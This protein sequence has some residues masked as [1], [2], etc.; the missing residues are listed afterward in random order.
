MFILETKSP[1]KIAELTY[2][3]GLLLGSGG[4]IVVAL[5]VAAPP[6]P[7]VVA[8]RLVHAVGEVEPAPA[9]VAGLVAVAVAEPGLLAPVVALGHVPR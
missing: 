5:S 9:H 4:L 2:D 6:L 7:H 8:L 3:R 1:N